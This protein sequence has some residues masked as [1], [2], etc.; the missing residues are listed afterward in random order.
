MADHN[1]L[2]KLG[3]QIAADYLRNKGF[4][5][6]ARNWRFKQK[7]VDIIAFDNDINFFLI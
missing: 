2:G 1:E 6:I 7:E 5:I 4:R 3:E